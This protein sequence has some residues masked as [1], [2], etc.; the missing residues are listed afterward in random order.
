MKN[1]T[2][3]DG[4]LIGFAL[5]MIL[6]F[7]FWLSVNGIILLIE[8]IVDKYETILYRYKRNGWRKKCNLPKI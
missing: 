2:Q 4:I 7:L 6:F 3:L 8:L 1:L 5:A